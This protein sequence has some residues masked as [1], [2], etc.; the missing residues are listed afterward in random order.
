[1]DIRLLYLSWKVTASDDLGEIGPEPTIGE[2]PKF[3]LSLLF[4]IYEA[5]SLKLVAE[6]YDPMED[7]ESLIRKVQKLNLI[8]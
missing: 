7:I 3:R 2:A 6:V 1:M 8:V 4:L 5:S